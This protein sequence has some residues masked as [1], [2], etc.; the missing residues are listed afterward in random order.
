MKENNTNSFPYPTD[1]NVAIFIEPEKERG[2]KDVVK[3]K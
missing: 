1:D 3:E 2:N